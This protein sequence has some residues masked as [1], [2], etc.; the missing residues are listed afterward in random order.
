MAPVKGNSFHNLKTMSRSA[1]ILVSK[2]RF[3]GGSD[4]KYRNV[5]FRRH[6]KMVAKILEYQT[7]AM[8]ID[9]SLPIHT[10]STP[11]IQTVPYSYSY[12]D[13]LGKRAFP[14]TAPGV[15][16][17]LPITLKTSVTIAIFR[18]IQE[19]HNHLA[20]CS[21]NL[22]PSVR[23]STFSCPTYTAP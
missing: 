21:I 2:Y 5:D 18:K 6:G 3:F 12:D 15:W 4:Y 17:E 20:V 19:S 11:K 16:N 14:V 10:K 22:S 8:D 13:Q 1:I 23:K 9:L 7:C